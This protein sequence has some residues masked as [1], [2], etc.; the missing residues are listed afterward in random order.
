MASI[1]AFVAG[2]PELIL[3]LMYNMRSQ[4]YA[5]ALPMPLVIGALKRL[6]L[7]RNHPEYREK[8]LDPLAA[9]WRKYRTIPGFTEEGRCLL[10]RRYAPWNWARESLSPYSL[11]GRV[12]EPEDR[13]KVMDAIAAYARIWFDLLK[14]AEP[15]KDPQYKQEV[16]TRKKFLQK[17]YRDRD[18]G[19]EVI[20]KIFGDDKHHLFVSLIF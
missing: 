3:Y 7:I 19:G 2:T 16:L 12:V 1:G 18:P 17:I 13:Y 5:K 11:D 15:M 9:D 14:K 6:E 4:V 20:K 8:Y 10:Q